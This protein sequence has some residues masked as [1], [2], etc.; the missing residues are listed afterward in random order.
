MNNKSA[1]SIQPLAD[2]YLFN[3]DVYFDFLAGAGL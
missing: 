2:F 3:N 1:K